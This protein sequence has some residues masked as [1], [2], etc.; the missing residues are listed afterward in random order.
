MTTLGATRILKQ[1][2]VSM[3]YTLPPLAMIQEQSSPY[4]SMA[5]WLE[6]YSTLV[7]RGVV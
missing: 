4:K 1:T 7:Q 6:H 5:G 2:L 3:K